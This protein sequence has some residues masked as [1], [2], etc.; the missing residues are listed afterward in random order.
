MEFDGKLVFLHL[1]SEKELKLENG[2]F[3]FSAD[4]IT[5]GHMHVIERIAKIC[6]DVLV[7]IGINSGKEYMFS[8][9]ER[10]SMARRALAVF[11]N[12]RVEA[13]DG[14]AVD[15]AAKN[16][17]ET[18]FKGIRDEKDIEYEEK[19]ARLGE[20]QYAGIKTR[21]LETLAEFKDVSSTN[22]KAIVKFNG[23]AEAFVPLFV[24][25][26]LEARM[27][28]QYIVGVAGLPGCGKTFIS[29]EL[30]QMGRE[31]NIPIYN[32]DVDLLGH[33]IGLS[34]KYPGFEKI[35]R[36]I[37]KEFGDGVLDVNGF[38]NRKNLGSIVFGNESKLKTLNALMRPMMDVLLRDELRGKEGII[39]FNAALIPDWGMN[40][41]CNNN[42]VLINCEK[43][44]EMERLTG[45]RGISREKAEAMIASQWSFEDKKS[46]MEQQINEGGSGHLWVFE[47]TNETPQE[48][49]D[50]LFNG[51]LGAATDAGV[52]F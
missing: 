25:E 14:F 29:N 38:V 46:F 51:L 19:L 50:L 10:L 28:N 26:A 48:E 23:H 41:I 37:A 1:G 31:R 40:H 7:G 36:E 8:L 18:I 20:T 52:R 30:V 32:I 15:F 21:Y 27:L 22:A 39:L 16:G 43:E 9:E 11:P 47:S 6:D 12:V 17:I 45:G 49:F 5:K 35:R 13:F 3:T 24:K 34:S 33:E 42:L 44:L 4:P 2:L